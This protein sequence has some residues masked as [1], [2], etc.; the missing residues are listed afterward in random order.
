M[1]TTAEAPAEKPQT[2]QAP[3]GPAPPIEVSG[4]GHGFGDLDVLADLDLRVGGS[5]VVGLV[6]PSGCGK[7]TLLELIAGLTAQR[8]GRI[9]VGGASAP[10]ERLTRCAYMPQRDLLLPWLPAIDNAGLALRNRGSSRAEARHEA[11][12][13][14]ERLEL[15]CDPRAGAVAAPQ[16]VDEDVDSPVVGHVSERPDRCGRDTRILVVED[17]PDELGN[18]RMVG[19]FEPLQCGDATPSPPLRWRM[20][21]NAADESGG[22]R[23]GERG[24]ARATQSTV[25]PDAPENDDQRQHH[26]AREGDHEH[27]DGNAEDQVVHLLVVVGGAL[28][29]LPRTGDPRHRHTP[30][31]MRMRGLEPLNASDTGRRLATYRDA[32]DIEPSR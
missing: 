5:E 29:A 22:A 3:A 11:A 4:L 9:A 27:G 6:G 12:P 25:V 23:R 31:G 1:Q 26:P 13:L 2:P 8:T 21:A 10:G 14:F 32:L 18:G 24:R 17:D 19:A 30:Y 7:S 28:A 20:R 16:R 15:G